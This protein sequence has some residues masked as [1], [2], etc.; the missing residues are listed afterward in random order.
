M[1][2]IA[3]R[4]AWGHFLEPV[5]GHVEESLDLGK[6]LGFVMREG[7]QVVPK[8]VVVCEDARSQVVPRL[9]TTF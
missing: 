9:L 3:C 8:V 1:K 5:H 2:K 4:Q 7:A 6:Q